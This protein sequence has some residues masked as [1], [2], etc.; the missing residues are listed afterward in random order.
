[1]SAFHGKI[2][3]IDNNLDFIEEVHKDSKLISDYPL[4]VQKSLREGMKFFEKNRALTRAVVCSTFFFQTEESLQNFQNTLGDTPY[5]IISHKKNHSLQS[6]SNSDKHLIEPKSYKQILLSLKPFLEKRADWK[7]VEEDGKEKFVE[8]QLIDAEYISVTLKDFMI[9]PKSYFNIFIKIGPGNYIK[10]VNAGDES[11]SET[12]DRYAQK[13]FNMLYLPLKEHEKYLSLCERV[14]EKNFASFTLSSKEKLK[15][16]FRLGNEVSKNI[17]L[18][19]IEPK[20]LDYAE[21]FLDQSVSMIKNFHIKDGNLAKFIEDIQHNDHPAAVSFLSGVIAN[22]LGFESLKS[23][24]LVGIAALVHDVGL[25]DLDPQADETILP[26]GSEI[27][28]KHPKHGADLLRKSGCFDEV[29]CLAVEQH[30]MR[31]RGGE[32]SMRTGNMN[33]VSEIVGVS[34]IFYNLV[35]KDGLTSTNLD[36]FLK[37]ELKKFSPSIEKSVLKVLDKKKKVP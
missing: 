15:S 18:M 1:M 21:T 26:Q 24:K 12:I 9:F 11:G 14:S 3:L 5:I 28:I 33:L 27:M 7:Q 16:T 37:V 31:R 35:I 22:E 30:H 6:Q 34:D 2:L 20:S 17:Q 10:I 13:G 32:T 36:F 23:V 25:F 8:L 29:V 4:L 19:G